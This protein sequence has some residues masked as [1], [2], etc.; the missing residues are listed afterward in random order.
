VALDVVCCFAEDNLTIHK[1]L[2][3]EPSC[4]TCGLQMSVGTCLRQALFAVAICWRGGG[5]LLI[6]MI[7]SCLYVYLATLS[8]VLRLLNVE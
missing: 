4:I 8:H 5:G 7:Q 6:Y 3:E 1:G 2:T